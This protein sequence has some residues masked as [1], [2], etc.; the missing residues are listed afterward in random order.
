MTDMLVKAAENVNIVNNLNNLLMR[1]GHGRAARLKSR[2]S[3]QS[4]SVQ[5]SFKSENPAER[6]LWQVRLQEKNNVLDV[7]QTFV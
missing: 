2:I 4:C 7:S 1:Y 5:S 3:N 6:I